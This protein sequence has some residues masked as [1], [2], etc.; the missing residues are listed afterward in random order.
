MIIK[1]LGITDY[2]E[3][4]K[5]MQV[6]TKNRSQ[7]TPDELWLTQ[8]NPVFTTGLSIKEKLKPID[9]IPIIATDRGGKITYHG[10]G[11]LVIYLLINLKN[12]QF[13]VKSL[14]NKIEQSL[15]T[16]LKNYDISAVRKDT[17]PGVYVDNEKIAALGLKIKNHCTYH[18]LSLNISMDLNPF[19]LIN[20]CGYQGL[21]VTQMSDKTTKSLEF[22]KISQQLCKILISNL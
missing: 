4:Y 2:Q 8:H 18:G 16:L 3:T 13:S 6:W 5:K 20:P 7:T 15:I 14:V 19:L 10:L 1:N 22:N 11:Q 21:S 9:N 17:A 12:Q